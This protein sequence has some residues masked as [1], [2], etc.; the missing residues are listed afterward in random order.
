MID[1][2]KRRIYVIWMEITFTVLM[3][4]YMMF[5]YSD[6]C[7][8]SDWEK[9]TAILALACMINQ[10]L[11]MSMLRIKIFDF[12]FIFILLGYLFMFGRI[13]MY[14]LGQEV[15]A[16]SDKRVYFSDAM[17][18]HAA[19]YVLVSM[20]MLYTGMLLVSGRKDKS[21]IKERKQLYDRHKAAAAGKWLFAI[22]GICRIY[23]DTRY[24]IA[25]WAVK[26][27]AGTFDV[28]QSGIIDD[29]SWLLIPASFMIIVGSKMK[30][31]KAG[32]FLL[33]LSGYFLAISAMTGIR[34]L[35]IS[36][37]IAF[38]LFYIDYYK[39]KINFVK[40]LLTGVL[41][42]WGLNIIVEIRYSRV[43]NLGS[44]RTLFLAMTSE[45]RGVFQ[46]ISETASEFG[47]S[48]YSVVNVFNYVPAV[49]RYQLGSYFLY[50]LLV[51]FPVGPI[52][53]YFFQGSMSGAANSYMNIGVGSSLYSD[54]YANFGY[55]G[56]AV[57][58]LIGILMMKSLAHCRNK[59]SE[60]YYIHYFTLIFA[61]VNLERGSFAEMA[62]LAAWGYFIPVFMLRHL[63]FN[64][65]VRKSNVI[66]RVMG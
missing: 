59:Y 29:L 25:A 13:F 58:L 19:M 63:R 28:V 39:I 17:Q 16:M 32:L 12:Q 51:I 53:R 7:M 57:S 34:R 30:K 50:C 18:Y 14:A 40:L 22:A 55:F 65:T 41:C 9:V 15:T 46:I 56:M 66:G 26:G 49:Q 38:F 54:L 60:T 10:V 8:I 62:R 64:F 47:V 20:Q 44:I 45:G 5:S 4:L 21:W 2:G 11:T 43:M 35:Q 48:F 42:I 52:A 23:I 61:Y 37:I 6:E 36:A 33:I 27:Y 1:R 31:R 3:V 24:I